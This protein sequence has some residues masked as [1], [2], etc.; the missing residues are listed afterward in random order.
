[1]PFAIDL[2]KDFINV[3][4]V[5][6]APAPKALALLAGQTLHRFYQFRP[7]NLAVTSRA[8]AD[9]ISLLTEVQAMTASTSKQGSDKL[10]LRGGGNQG[11]LSQATTLAHSPNSRFLC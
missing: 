11:P 1:M 7:V 3:E 5:T 9:K 6:V 4:R 10:N 2:H 8:K